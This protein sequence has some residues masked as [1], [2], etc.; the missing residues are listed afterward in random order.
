MAAKGDS[1]N[2]WVAVFILL[3]M[4]IP[5]S[6]LLRREWQSQQTQVDQR[7]PLQGLGYCSPEQITPC[8]LSFNLDADD[9]MIVSILTEG[10]SFPS[11][12]LKIKHSKGESFYPCRRV[13]ESPTHMRCTGAVLPLGET[14]QF[15]LLATNGDRVL[16]QGNFPIIGL[17]L[18]TPDIFSSPTLGTPSP[19]LTVSP[20][21]TTTPVGTTPALTS[22][23]PPS[24]P[25][26][27][28]PTPAYPNPKP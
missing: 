21:G 22:T 27:S 6:I 11:F 2:R 4:M 24:Y 25:N 16:A 7:K 1:V 10:L 5:G 13:E 8:I 28:T 14:F 19:S 9:R 3:I 23:T 20:T 18:G 15:F 17:A 12:Y 26:P